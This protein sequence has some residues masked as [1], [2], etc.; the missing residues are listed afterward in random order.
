MPP[1]KIREMTWMAISMMSKTFLTILLEPWDGNDDPV[2]GK[3]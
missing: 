2:P 3:R 1:I